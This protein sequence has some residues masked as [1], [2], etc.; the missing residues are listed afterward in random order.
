[1]VVA[2]ETQLAPAPF[3][4]ARRLWGASEPVLLW[5]RDGSGPSFVTCDPVATSGQL[6]P[7]PGLPL[8]SE[9]GRWGSAPRWVGLLPY[10]AQRGRLERRAFAGEE[11]RPLPIVSEVRWYR[12]PA[13]AVIDHRVTVVGEN[14]TA[15]RA[16]IDRL[17]HGSQVA[18]QC[19]AEPLPEPGAQEA[20]R[21]RIAQ[22]LE[23]IAEGDVYQVNLARCVRL[24]IEGSSLGALDAMS[25]W[26]PAPYCAALSQRGSSAGTASCEGTKGHSSVE[27]VSTSPE[28]FLRLLPSGRVVTEPIKGTRPRGGNAAEDRRLF[29]ELAN[30]PK[31]Q[32]ELMMVVDVERNDLG[33]VARVGSVVTEPPLVRRH[34]TVYHR[35]ARVSA[36]LAPGVTRRQL[37]EA[38][39]P[40]GSV[41]GAPKVRAMELIAG[42]ESERRGL[43]TG[44]LGY[45]SHDGGAH[46]SMAIRTLCRSGELAHYHVGGGIVFDSD[47]DREV[48]ETS[49]KAAQLLRLFEGA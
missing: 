3:E 31:E 48:Q 22:A 42:L 16:L 17:R 27:V 6:D 35:E 37:F 7:E 46:L 45:I 30:D 44:A 14:L 29:H 19:T 24:R 20:H 43:Y 41:T 12:Y 36:R 25:R 1:M 11:R 13:V 9:L 39:L 21:H 38:M 40:S 8:D 15:V 18:T 26:A 34:G 47:P 5:T 28:L 49:W 33:R 23:H 4:L 2:I 10:E 32:A